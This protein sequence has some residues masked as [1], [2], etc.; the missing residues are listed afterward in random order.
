MRQVKRDVVPK[1]TVDDDYARWHSRKGITA[2][3]RALVAAWKEHPADAP[4][5]RALT[6]FASGPRQGSCP[7]YAPGNK[8]NAKVTSKFQV[9]VPRSGSFMT[10]ARIEALPPPVPAPPR[11][12]PL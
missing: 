8:R 11:Q 12:P 2:G 6:S 3:K 1:H 9:T 5:N 10:T 7:C 4:A